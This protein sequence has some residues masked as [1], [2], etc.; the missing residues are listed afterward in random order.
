MLPRL[1]P[2]LVGAHGDAVDQIKMQTITAAQIAA[3]LT[4]SIATTEP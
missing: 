4:A 1:R 2:G 3:A